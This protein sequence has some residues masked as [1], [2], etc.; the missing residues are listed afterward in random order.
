MAANDIGE[1]TLAVKNAA[2][3]G[4]L[5]V[6][7]TVTYKV[8]RYDRS[9]TVKVT[10]VVTET[11]AP[12]GDDD[13]K[14]YSIAHAL[15]INGSSFWSR[16]ASYNRNRKYTET[17]STSKS[18]DKG[19]GQQDLDLRYTVTVG[20]R[21]HSKTATRSM[22]ALKDAFLVPTWK[23][24]GLGV[25]R[26]GNA[27]TAKW[28]VP[29]AATN[30]KNANRFTGLQIQW[31][32]D[33]T[34]SL[35]DT[36]DTDKVADQSATQNVQTYGEFKI[37]G[38]AMSR[39]SFAPTG[40]YGTVKAVKVR[41][42][43]VHKRQGGRENTLLGPWTDWAT[44]EFAKPKAPTVTMELGEDNR[45]MTMTVK[46]D[47][48]KDAHER[49]RT[50]IEY[51]VLKDGK[52][53]A[54]AVL[55][56]AK[57]EWSKFIDLST[58]LAGLAAGQNV[59]VVCFAATEGI[60]G[61]TSAAV[62]SH[63]VAMPGTPVINSI[64]CTDKKQKGKIT[65]KVKPGKYTAQ[66][67]LERKHDDG[68]P[69]T[70]DGAVDDGDAKA[71]YDSFGDV[72]P[73]GLTGTGGKVYYRLKATRDGYTVYSAWKEAVAL[74]DPKVTPK[75]TADVIAG[76]YAPDI[77]ATT[78]KVSVVWMDSTDNH[79]FELS[80]SDD[81][82]AWKS[83][84]GPSTETYAYG[85]DHG[86]QD[87][88]ITGL[89]EG[90]TYYVRARRYRDID[91]T[92]GRN[93]T[94]QSANVTRIYSAYSPAVAFETAS[95]DTAKMEVVGVSSSYN[96]QAGTVDAA[97]AVTF[98]EKVAHTGTELS[99][100][101]DK[102]AWGA[103]TG[104]PDSAE[105]PDSGAAI[106]DMGGGTSY[107]QLTISG[108]EPGETYYVRCRRYLTG[109]VESHS[110]YFP[111]KPLAFTT[112]G[113]SDDQCKV[114]SAKSNAAGDGAK[115][116]IHIKQDNVNTGTEVAWSTDR[117]AFYSNKP[118]ETMRATWGGSANKENDKSEYPKSKM[119]YL[120]GLTPGSEYYVWAR[121]Y[122][123]TQAG[124]D[125]GAWSTGMAFATKSVVEAESTASDD[126]CG[127]VSA[128]ATGDGTS[129]ELVS[130]WNEDDP[131]ESTEV[132]WS[133]DS[134][135]WQANEGPQSMEATWEDSKSQ[136]AKWPKTQTVYL[137]GLELGQSYFVRARR[138]GADGSY[139]PYSK[140]A[141]LKTPDVRNAPDV[142]CGIVSLEQVDGTT[143]R[144]VI[145]WSGDRDG[146]E[147]TWSDDQNAWESTEGPQS[148]T[149]EWQDAKR[150]STAWA[151]TGTLYITDLT[152]GTR[153]FV[154]ART[155][156][157]GD[158]QVWSDYTEEATVTCVT[159]PTAVSL[160][161]P[162]AIARGDS[163]ELYWTVEHDLDQTEWHVHKAASATSY[164]TPGKA[165][166]SGTGSLAHASVPA[167]RYG[168]ATSVYLY[169]SAGCGGG[170]T[171]SNII[172]VGIADRPACEGS[173]AP[174]V[175]AKP[176]TAYAYTDDPT[177]RLFATLRS[178]GVTFE[179]PDGDRDQLA[180][181]VVWTAAL[182][183]AW[184][185]S[186]WGATQ[187]RQQLLEAVTAAQAAYDEA[188]QGS[189]ADATANALTALQD[190]QAALAAH[191][192]DG[193]CY[194]AAFEVPESAELV[195][196]GT[197]DLTLSAVERTAGL[198]SAPH[199]C[200]AT[201]EWAHQAPEPAD[202]IAV[203]PDADA[204]SVEI[205]L[206]QPDGWAETD[207]YDLYRMTPTGHVLVARGLA[208]DDTVDDPYAPFGNA[209]L[210]YRVATRTADGDV[211]FADYGYEMD[212]RTLRFDWG[213]ESVE[214]PY[215]IEVSDSYEKSFEARA[216]VD[217]G[218]NGYYDRAVT[219]S[220]SYTA[221]VVKSDDDTIT[222]LRRLGEHPG[223][224]F[225]RTPRGDAF[226][227]NVDLGSLD[228][229]YATMAVG[230]SFPITEMKLTPEFMARK[231]EV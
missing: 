125:Y 148:K 153:Y 179:A 215:N 21:S 59:T 150:Q 69:E 201:V 93:A 177:A 143:A 71:L 117:N 200:S 127:I 149:F 45:T 101:K 133:T 114:Y 203:T 219:H 123:E 212:V 62:V 202:A 91:E 32:L 119:V 184:A 160:A 50:T 89:T 3:D 53:K 9:V 86:N 213:A 97:V 206:A 106:V 144:L 115:V 44:Y 132:T 169:V 171:D 195:D 190:A 211:A 189:D 209:D 217:G 65:V 168:S 75:C 74:R 54:S 94:A 38:K 33:R 58:Y 18:F 84:S 83:G 42:R 67:Q 147:A 76:P 24:N 170:L 157:D 20:P 100:S 210:H 214:V 103:T 72:W 19:E 41:V 146:C 118:P 172:A 145:G 161:G 14:S 137:R 167:S 37:G 120:R 156:A 105:Y 1:Y 111:K 216:H 17:Q 82:N 138:K 96:R 155:W 57:T 31:K 230:A 113:A 68:S 26:D 185:G 158:E 223:A 173:T 151:H 140:T 104:G 182:N 180:G 110:D 126:S 208:A 49:T 139:S 130:G 40:K 78:Q 163:I 30:S 55:T 99:W 122:L 102:G 5:K 159:A 193:A 225:C 154:R 52:H 221:D 87:V 227:A 231:R 197:Y 92:T 166:A 199:T 88:T 204:R 60:A 7:A 192:A 136:S 187:L 121:Q 27:F 66:L 70:V 226:Q 6:T 198:S 8:Y 134:G 46:S 35:K 135:A 183:A 222:A 12:T 79:G 43:G 28:K 112:E 25:T 73:N 228:L 229:S 194:V 196:G 165:L 22:D 56:T 36:V 116:V 224:V 218:V 2:Y 95:V 10:K 107:A 207:V 164:G 175:T 142:R 109:Q 162:T 81:K 205:A 63:T 176:F 181:D 77:N 129:G 39:A 23:V 85:A 220:G 16:S 141:T 80:W 98:K 47:E 15:T 11:S 29:S 51:N 131:N 188:A 64:A 4:G 174:V 178:R 61:N 108:L 34:G 124:T 48:G 90:V 13:P 186:T 128:T 191:P 152:E